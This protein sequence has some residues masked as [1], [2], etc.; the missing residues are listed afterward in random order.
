[1]IVSQRVRI[2]L[3]FDL[4][5]I[6]GVALES[7]IRTDALSTRRIRV[8]AFVVLRRRRNFERKSERARKEHSKKDRKCAGFSNVESHE[9]VKDSFVRCCHGAEPSPPRC[10]PQ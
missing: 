8:S 7:L 6:C 10:N 5:G 4:I 9:L 3:A 2:K 1:M